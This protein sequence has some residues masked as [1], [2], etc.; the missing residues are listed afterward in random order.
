M[1]LDCNKYGD[2]VVIGNPEHNTNQG[3]VKIFKDNAGTDSQNIGDSFTQIYSVNGN[4]YNYFGLSVSF[5]DS[6]NY[7]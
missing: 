2:L 6:G 3:N 7:L 1:S 4:S 5:N